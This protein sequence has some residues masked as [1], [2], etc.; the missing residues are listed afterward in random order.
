MQLIHIYLGLLEIHSFVAT[1]PW[2]DEWWRITTLFE[3]CFSVSKFSTF[4]SADCHSEEHQDLHKSSV[5]SGDNQKL[6][7]SH[8]CWLYGGMCWQICCCHISSI[9]SRKSSNSSIGDFLLVLRI[10]LFCGMR[11]YCW[12][13]RKL[14]TFALIGKRWSVYLHCHYAMTEMV[15]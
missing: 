9:V 1:L 5:H 8:N 2:P 14:Q 15:F 7:L 10:I 12:S 4:L 11:L 6:Q 3:V 13:R